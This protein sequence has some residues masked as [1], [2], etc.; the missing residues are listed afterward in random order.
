MFTK[1]RLE[2]LNRE[3]ASPEN[4]PKEIIKSLNIQK[5]DK[6]GDIGS[7]GGYYTLKFAKEVG[8][9]GMVYAIDTKQEY[10]TFIMG[11]IKKKG[12]K[13]IKTLLVNKD[14]FSIPEKVDLFFVRNVFHHLPAPE[15]YFKNIK[16]YLKNDGRIAI[17]EHKRRKYS[18]TG[19][20]G[21]FTPKDVLI[22]KM[23]KAGFKPVDRL[24]FLP[25]QYF[26]IFKMK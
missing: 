20:F 18:F 12:L 7:G 1:F 23:G 14:G 24:D 22:D 25:D 6:V 5:N 19:I 8:E 26:I 4:K 15:D 9:E 21:H 10:L 3:A 17:I 13:N 16:R 11:K 2:M